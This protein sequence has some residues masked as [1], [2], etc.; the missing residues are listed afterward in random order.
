MKMHNAHSIS[1]VDCDE[2]SD[3][4]FER[5]PGGSAVP[6]TCMKS[7]EVWLAEHGLRPGLGDCSKVRGLQAPL[8]RQH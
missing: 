3:S 7:A 2:V 4:R 5:V 1:P 6:F 8:R